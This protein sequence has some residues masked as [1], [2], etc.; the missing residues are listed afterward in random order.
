MFRERA[1]TIE[2]LKAII[3]DVCWR[4]DMKY[5]SELKN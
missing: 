2:I 5:A 4:K 1:A 3:L